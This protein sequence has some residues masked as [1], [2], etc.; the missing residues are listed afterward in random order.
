MRVMRVSAPVA[1]AL[2]LAALSGAPAI[3]AAP[4]GGRAQDLMGAVNDLRASYGLSPFTVDPILMAVAQKQND[5]SISIGE[6]THYGPDG[7]RPRDQVIA[8]GYGGGSTVFVSENIA[9]GTGL[10][11]ADAVE[12]WTGDDP[13]LNTMIGTYYRDV[14]AAAGERDGAW[15]YTLIAAYVAGGTS[16]HSTAP[17]GGISAPA[18]PAPVIQS[19]AQADG[20]IVH[21]VESGQTLWT[22][23]AVYGVDL[24]D[25][26]KQNS[27]DEGAVLHPGDR[28]VIRRGLSPSPTMIPSTPTGRTH[29]SATALRQPARTASPIAPTATPA[30]PEPR[31]VSTAL[32]AAG[33]MLL[34]FG[35]VL[36]LRGR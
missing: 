24:E 18:G 31:P 12:M 1:L 13:H 9:M 14:G 6:I 23:A 32:I 21:I 20:S 29:P 36:G 28:V 15:Y 5:Y 10:S 22:L 7:S 26:L 19:T 8:A 3:E 2:F 34:A 33:L 30:A 35:L 16:A 17:V 4:P 27:L 25:L 11:P